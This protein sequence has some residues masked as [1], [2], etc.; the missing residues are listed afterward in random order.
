MRNS[1]K[2]LKTVRALATRTSRR[3]FWQ[4][5][6]LSVVPCRSSVLAGEA[7]GKGKQAVNW[8]GVFRSLGFYS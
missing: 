2:F 3:A 1:S 5:E 6:Q 8:K 7:H 4:K